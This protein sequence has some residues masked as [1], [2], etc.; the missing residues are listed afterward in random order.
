MFHQSPDIDSCEQIHA[1][2]QQRYGRR[3]LVG[4][5]KPNL[6]RP[7]LQPTEVDTLCRILRRFLLI[8]TMRL[9]A[10]YRTVD[11]GY[12]YQRS[13]KQSFLPDGD[14]VVSV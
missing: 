5:W 14:R 12:R 10:H 6:W 11:E 2:G 8:Q 9:D 4:K 7:Y 1:D 3:T 13:F